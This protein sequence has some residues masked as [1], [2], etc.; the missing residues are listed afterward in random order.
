MDGHRT[1]RWTNPAGLGCS[2][3][4]YPL[5]GFQLQG[6][7]SSFCPH[8]FIQTTEINE[9]AKRKYCTFK[10]GKKFCLFTLWMLQKVN[11]QTL[12]HFE[13]PVYKLSLHRLARPNIALT[14]SQWEFLL[15]LA[16]FL[17]VYVIPKEKIFD[18]S[19]FCNPACLGGGLVCPSKE[20][21]R[22]EGNHER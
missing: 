20:A 9:Q 14:S 19:V 8:K 5:S 3:S 16:E 4:L 2:F 22:W 13:S 12:L 1:Y 6:R 18:C 21:S 17:Q 15:T 10:G 7:L 11:P